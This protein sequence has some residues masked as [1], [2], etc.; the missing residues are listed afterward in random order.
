MAADGD[1]DHFHGHPSDLTGNVEELTR[2][3]SAWI[4][5]SIKTMNNTNRGEVTSDRLRVIN[6]ET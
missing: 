6:A 3:N 4:K 2:L 1:A 5:A